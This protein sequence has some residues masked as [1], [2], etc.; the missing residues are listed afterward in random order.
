MSTQNIFETAGKKQTAKDFKPAPEKI[1]TN[2]GT[3]KF[4]GGAFPTAKTSAK[5]LR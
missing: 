3:L 4:V 2:F 5:A 1:K